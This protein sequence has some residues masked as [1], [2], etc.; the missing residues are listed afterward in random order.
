MSPHT[1]ATAHRAGYAQFWAIILLL[2]FPVVA[3]GQHQGEWYVQPSTGSNPEKRHESAFVRVGD[4]FYL[5]GGRGT[6]TIQVYD[7]ESGSWRNT[8]SVTNNI[9]HFQARAF[10]GKIYLLGAL[11]GGYPNEDPLPNVLIYDPVADELQTGPVIPP[12]RRRGSSGVALYNGQFYII[13]G[14]R[15]GHSA[16]LENSSEPANVA[17][18]DR[19]DPVT[20]TWTVLPDAPHARDHF[21]A[22]VIGSRIYVAGGRRSKAGTSAGTWSDT[23]AAVDVFDL[24]AGNWVTGTP[25]PDDLPT[26]R[27]GAATAVVNGEL[28]VIGGEI[29]TNPPANLALP[30]TEVLNPATGSWRRLGDLTLPRH[31]TQAIVYNGDVYVAAGSRTKGGTEI[32]AEESFIEAFSYDGAPGTEYSDWTSI[33]TS[34]LAKSEAQMVAFGGEFYI[35]N[36]FRVGVDIANT[37]DKYNPATRR[38]TSLQY[39]PTLN[40]TGTA[41]THH[42]IALVGDTVWIVG[43]R[44][45]DH[46]GPVTD[47]VW[48]Y[49]ISENTWSPGPTLPLRRGGGGLAR[50]GNELH[51]VGGFDEFASCD[52]D[53]HLVLDLKAL[54]WGWQDIT[55]TAPM[56]MA[57]NHFSTVTL[58]GK[59]YTIGGQNGHDGCGGGAD[60]KLVHVYDPISNTWDR[61]ADL[62]AIQSH[63]EPSTFVHNG[64]ILLVGGSS[65]G[66]KGVWEYDAGENAWSVLTGMQLPVPLLAP[67]ARVYGG[68]L[69]VMNGGQPGTGSPVNVVRIKDFVEEEAP[70][71]AFH[72]G[73]MEVTL[74]AGE[75]TSRKVI[76]AN[77]NGES[78]TPFQI[79]SEDLPPWLS[80]DR[81]AGMARE[82]F[83]ELTLSI[84]TEGLTAGPYTYLL[85]AEAQEYASA[86]LTVVLNVAGAP[87]EPDG[88]Y[89]EFQEAECATVGSN[90]VIVAD[91]DASEGQYVSPK[92]GLSVPLDQAPADGPEHW[93]SFAFTT[94][95]PGT[96]SLSA[97]IVAP[98]NQKD[99]FW[100]RVNG[101]QWR[102]WWQG[103]RTNSAYTWKEVLGSP[104]TLPAGTVVVDIAYREP[105]TRLDKLVLHANPEMPTGS[106]EPATN[107]GGTPPPTGPDVVIRLNA[108]GPAVNY[109]GDTYAADTYFTGGKSYTNTSARVADIYQTERS[110]DA[111][112]QFAYDIPV[113][114]GHYRVRLH[115]AEIYFGAAGGGAGGTGKRVFDV[116]L[117]DELIL[118]DFDITAEVG[119]EAILVKS[120]DLTVSDGEINLFFNAASA[121]GGID[122]PKLSALEVISLEDS[123][124]PSPPTSSW[125]E[126][127]CAQE[128]SNWVTATRATASGGRYLYYP[129]NNNFSAPSTYGGADQ[130][131]YPLTVSEAGTYGLYL[132]LDAP[133]TGKNSFWVS[134]DEGPWIKFWRQNGSAQLRTDGFEWR[135]LT[136]EEVPARFSLSPGTH[137]IRVAPRETG[138]ELDKLFLTA[139]EATPT[140]MGEPT[141]SCPQDQLRSLSDTGVKVTAPATAAQSIQLYPNPVRDLLRI[142]LSDSGAAGLVIRV[143]NVDGKVLLSRRFDTETD[144][145]QIVELDVRPFP[146]GTYLLQVI[147]AEDD[148][149]RSVPFVKQ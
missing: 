83:T 84:D 48:L 44:I 57:R 125:V 107:C 90:W 77:L 59:L 135:I 139:G 89:R 31:A 132:R 33:G 41:V 145:D 16:T 52:V 148:T 12:A 119:P 42:G 123:G 18:M 21:F 97:R 112:Y 70:A 100:V 120:Y 138:T 129:G 62:P 13:A 55:A 101:G 106:G 24:E 86:T 47:A 73:S 111:P 131:T 17:W 11:T 32:T 85:R 81:T 7:P 71:L 1:D 127:E 26:E 144:A 102:K 29:N 94:P 2:V 74:D 121:V 63:A 53:I 76:L 99:S 45:G 3:I 5:I 22:E 128:G 69:F 109:A 68:T 58:G 141:T 75:A 28:I 113:V 98:T 9:H 96:Y 126:A 43:G 66:G 130:L 103:L 146:P 133:T 136:T 14:N 115:F 60:N 49:D 38:W 147:G 87:S 30:H 92:P 39:M 37:V 78:E 25:L 27:A 80:I 140:G 50:L 110:S 20:G 51:Y 118:D 46:P 88:P 10:G 93:T 122:Q 117:E 15:N 95:Q 19:Y 79:A 56:P 143:L 134:V 91:A 142:E 61:L 114:A 65:S 35:F 4:L 137:R 67:A 149:L 104:F 54:E 72:P 116:T 34:P 124:E 40:G 8:N 23:E 6:K 82:S 108:G 105:G 36:G 64:K